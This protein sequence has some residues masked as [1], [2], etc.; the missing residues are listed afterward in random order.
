MTENM[1]CF[2]CQRRH[3]GK[4]CPVRAV[5]SLGETYPGWGNGGKE[6]DPE[7]WNGDNIT[8]ECARMWIEFVNR[9][10]LYTNPDASGR[11]DRPDFLSVAAQVPAP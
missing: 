1:A 11:L 9:H 8:P 2:E 3:R 10:H 4:E 5:E 7:L 6:R